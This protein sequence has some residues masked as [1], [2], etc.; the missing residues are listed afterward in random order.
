[1]KQAD[2]YKEISEETEVDKKL[3]ARVIDSYLDNIKRA[4]ASGDEFKIGKIG[5]FKP[6][7]YK[8][9]TLKAIS[10]KTVTTSDSKTVKFKPF[11]WIKNQLN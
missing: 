3:V 5:V 2:L 7:L 10:G 11:K 8:G 6:S 9:R 1:M 4:I